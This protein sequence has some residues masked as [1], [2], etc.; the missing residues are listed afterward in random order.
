[1]FQVNPPEFEIPPY[2][3]TRVMLANEIEDRIDWGQKLV[4]LPAAARLTKGKGI[5]IAILDTGID[6]MHAERGDLRG[7][8]VAARNFTSA[9]PN[10]FWDSPV[11]GHGTHCAGVV[12]GREN[13]SGIV[14]YAPQCELLIGRCL[15][16]KKGRG[17]WLANGLLWALAEGADVI[18]CSW[19]SPDQDPGIA[20]AIEKCVSAGKFVV[21]AA[22][23]TGRPNDVNYPA[24]WKAPHGH[25]NLDC[26][27]VAAIQRDGTLAPYSSRGPEV[28]C[29]FPGS[30]VTSTW[31]GGG[32]ATM[33]GTSMACPGVAAVVGLLLAVHRQAGGGTTPFRTHDEIRDHF[34][35][36]SQDKGPAGEDDGYGFGLP[37]IPDVL[38]G[39]SIP[40]K[41]GLPVTL[42]P[43]WP[44]LRIDVSL[45][46]MPATLVAV[47]R[48]K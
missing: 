30:E 26:L 2:E 34:R 40:D 11:D 6:R 33:D 35:K 19:G 42:P 21:A 4:G 5:R 48:G 17:T 12:G 23:N 46:G 20:A 9:D 7:A 13:N 39:V 29:C 15:T 24:R 36:Y 47:P 27:A 38:K 18:S 3:V 31:I 43:G 8:V 37:I 44:D 28:D 14:G 45:N 16:N 1:M 32:Y 25:P 41:P 22:G 10:D